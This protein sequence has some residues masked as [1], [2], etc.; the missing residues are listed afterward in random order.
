MRKNITLLSHRLIRAATV[1]REAKKQ[2]ISLKHHLTCKLFQVRRANHQG[3]QRCPYLS[4]SYVQVALKVQ[5]R[6]INIWQNC[7]RGG[8]S[9]GW[10]HWHSGCGHS[11]PFSV[12]G[13]FRCNIPASSVWCFQ[14]V[15]SEHFQWATV[16][17]FSNAW[18]NYSSGSV[19]CWWW[20]WCG[21]G[22]VVTSLQLTKSFNFPPTA[23]TL[24]AAGI[25][26]IL[27]NLWK[28]NAH[29]PGTPIL[30]K[31][32][33]RSNCVPSLYSPSSKK[34]CTAGHNQI[35]W[36]FPIISC[37]FFDL[38]NHGFWIGKFTDICA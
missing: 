32:R 25:H 17:T 6:R 28:G 24:A 30:R 12:C 21:G 1:T 37:N 19:Q 27:A 18:K 22:G 7:V 8:N 11:S 16:W 23:T 38:W 10:A 33:E 15:N 35:C 14:C 3:K 20:W 2:M 34:P 26:G 13:N 9:E 5:G 36:A 29:R 4:K 31:R